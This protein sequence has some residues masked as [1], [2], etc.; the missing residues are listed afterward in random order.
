[1]HFHVEPPPHSHQQ[2]N[3]GEP[4][5]PM[6]IPSHRQEPGAADGQSIMQGLYSR[7]KEN[8]EDVEEEQVTR[9]FIWWKRYVHCSFSQENPS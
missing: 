2:E 1:M 5:A 9:A 3:F 8:L 4:M 7:I 6:Q